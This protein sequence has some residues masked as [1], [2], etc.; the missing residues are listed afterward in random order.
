MKR[1]VEFPLD[2]GGS[3]VVEVDEPE[4]EG[5]VRVSRP[6]EVVTKAVQTFEDAMDAIKP[7]AGIIISKLR[8]L[9][10]PPDTIGVEFGIKL[11]IDAKAYIASVGAEANYKVSLTWHRKKESPGSPNP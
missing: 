2:G 11:N 10:E 6:G 5:V 3:V 9:A 1:L 8:S 4:G 7:A